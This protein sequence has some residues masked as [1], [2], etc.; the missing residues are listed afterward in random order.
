MKPNIYLPLI[1]VFLIGFMILFLGK[2]KSFGQLETFQILFQ[3]EHFTHCYDVAPTQDQGYIITGFEDRPA[4]FNMPLTPYLCKI[5]CQGKVEWVRKYGPTTGL[6]NSDPRVATLN[7][8]DYIMMNTVLESDYDILV[9]RTDVNGEAVWKKT[10]GGDEKDVGRGLLKLNDDNIIVV[11]STYSYG[12]DVA[13]FYSDMYALKINTETGDTIWTKTFGN[14]G[15]IDDLWGLTESENGELTFVGRSFYDNG[16]WLTLIH[17][18]AEG[19]LLWTKNYG[20]T[21]HH[22]QGFDIIT[23]PDGGFAFTG[24]TTLAKIDFNSLADMQ[25]IRTDA[26]GNI[27]WAKVFYGS[28]PDLSEV[29]S[30]LIAKGDT[31]AVALESSSYP[32]VAQD[33][34]KQMLYLLDAES[35]DLIHA[36]SFNG[37]G[38]QFPMIRKDRTGYIMSGMTDEFPGSWND[39][40]LRK[41]SDDFES[42]CQETDWTDLTETA[43]PVWDV[44]DASF[45]ISNG[46]W[47]KNYTIDS[48][49]ADYYVDST[50]CFS[51]EIPAFCETISSDEEKLFTAQF[52]VFPNPASEY[53][54][55]E[56]NG[57]SNSENH[58]SIFNLSGQKIRGGIMPGNSEFSM[59][60]NSLPSGI[61]FLEIK[62]REGVYVEKIE[63][64]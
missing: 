3:T 48:L 38:G 60:I 55:V 41:L 59:N 54:T 13:S 5:N 47:A 35:G 14:P 49:A 53:L 9:V 45:L 15:G 39:P 51:G 58:I 19:N 1:R 44:A 43:E 34:T 17:T 20:K 11:G 36:K 23:M 57:V 31:L 4:P 27:L 37:T 62:N 26:S 50:F 61:Y 29:G 33:I 2:N 16:I 42:G 52:K 40:I 7:S 46:G 8:G 63:K 6:D 10:Y 24:F 64:L 28:S 25:V 21:N 30:T 32:T 18:D 22:A 56:F 12:T